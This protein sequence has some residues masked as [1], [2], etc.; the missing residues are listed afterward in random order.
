[1]IW[2]LALVVMTAEQRPVSVMVSIP[3]AV[4]QAETVVLRM[5]GVVMRREKPAMWNVYWEKA[6]EAH[7]VG[8]V[9]SPANTATREPKPANFGLQLPTAALAA[10][11]RRR[12]MRFLFVPLRKPPEGGISISTVRLE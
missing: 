9:S 12:E 6:D 7:L 4:K 1:M 11:R 10:I 3:Q 8:Y 5:E 2:L